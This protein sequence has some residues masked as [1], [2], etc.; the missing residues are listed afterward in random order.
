VYLAKLETRR[1]KTKRLEGFAEGLYKLC[2]ER[3]QNQVYD[4]ERPY[5]LSRQA[6][7]EEL[8]GVCAMRLGYTTGLG[9]DYFKEY[10]DSSP[11]K[12]A[13]AI[14]KHVT[15]DTDR[16]RR[17]YDMSAIVTLR[18]DNAGN[19]Y[20]PAHNL[21]ADEQEISNLVQEAMTKD[22]WLRII[23]V[24]SQKPANLKRSER[25]ENELI[26]ARRHSTQANEATELTAQA[27]TGEATTD[28][29]TLESLITDV[30]KKQRREEVKDSKKKARKNYSGGRG[31]TT[32]PKNKSK[33]NGQSKN[34]TSKSASPKKRNQQKR[35][36]KGNG[37]RK[38]TPKGTAGK[39][40]KQGKGKRG[41]QEPS[42]KE[43]Q[44]G[45]ATKKR[46]RK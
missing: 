46:R 29:A 30:V 23:T 6:T 22:N 7:D 4:K 38:P 26:A 24:E 33:P 45:S 43:K 20:V 5:E 36:Q 40:R 32:T 1:A 39:Q 28:R 31:P 44:N 14:A 11:S 3:V 27:L 2:L 19:D 18:P 21:S 37:A 9:V 17:L 15:N 8:A 34:D 13:T 25:I 10:L 35:N 16:Q 41:R 12:V 42:S